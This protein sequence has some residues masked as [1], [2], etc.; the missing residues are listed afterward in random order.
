M[1]ILIANFVERIDVPFLEEAVIFQ[2]A[3]EA[4][5]AFGP[6]QLLKVWI[7]GSEG[8]GGVKLA[9]LLHLGSEGIETYPTSRKVFTAG[10]W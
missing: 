9:T 8:T 4:I 1:L 5:L 3:A 2:F 10:A 6:I 7:L